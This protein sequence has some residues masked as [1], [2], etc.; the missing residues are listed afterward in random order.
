MVDAIL[1]VITYLKL[2][3]ELENNFIQGKIISYNVRNH[4]ECSEEYKKYN[5]GNYEYYLEN[6]N[7]ADK[8][9]VKSYINLHRK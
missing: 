4:Y 2:F 6:I 8:N 5:E 1:Q 9:L 7:E 3:Q